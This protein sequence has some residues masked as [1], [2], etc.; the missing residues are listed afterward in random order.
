MKNL[1]L[2]FAI[3]TI[4]T[5]SYGQ[6][7]IRLYNATLKSTDINGTKN[8]KVK[9]FPETSKKISDP[10][11]SQTPI[12]WIGKILSQNNLRQHKTFLDLA[13]EETF[14]PLLDS[15]D[16]NFYSNYALRNILD[17]QLAKDEK[18]NAFR[19]AFKSA[20]TNKQKKSLLTD[21]LDNSIYFAALI[22]SKYQVDSTSMSNSTEVEKQIKLGI[23][24]SLDTLVM[25]KNLTGNAGILAELDK[26]V[27]KNITVKGYYFEV[28]YSKEYLSKV[29]YFLTKKYSV[30]IAKIKSATDKDQFTSTLID[31]YDH[32]YSAMIAGS[33][34]LKI[35]IDY[36][37]T[38]ISRDSIS[39]IISA[40]AQIPKVDLAKI[41]GDLH[42]AF[43][44][45]KTFKGEAKTENYYCVS[46]AYDGDIETF[47]NH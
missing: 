15:I 19:K 25:S 20:T 21:D 16:M 32:K 46:Y 11:L 39:A 14:Y 22:N 29:I 7:T 34:I 18:Y 28:R 41:T 43:G 42:A 24:L 27:D 30:D 8:F 36:N 35:T 1:F 47:G 17:K 44:L 26:M 4:H 37:V 12:Y 5:L 2:F 13:N 45:D 31:F 33:A 6:E 40:N 38:K 3:L 23:K 10:L 9:N